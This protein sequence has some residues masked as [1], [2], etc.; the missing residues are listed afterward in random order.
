MKACLTRS[1]SSTHAHAYWRLET[2]SQSAL[3]PTATP[4]MSKHG[5]GKMIIYDLCW[6]NNEAKLLNPAN[7]Y[8]VPFFGRNLWIF[9]SKFTEFGARKLHKLYKMAQKKRSHEEEASCLSFIFNTL[10]IECNVS[11]NTEM[12]LR[13]FQKE[14]KKKED[15]AGRG[16]PFRPEPS[17][18]SRDSTGTQ[19]S[20]KSGSHSTQ[21]G[22]HGHHREPY[23]VANK[24]HFGNDGTYGN[25]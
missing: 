18:S 6:S 12:D 8:F 20:S 3:K 15:P 2:E 23:N 4:N 13:H 22:P 14:Q 11:T 17:G 9:V 25:N 7:H 21:S 10:L 16:K 5:D 24:R 19:P 1:S